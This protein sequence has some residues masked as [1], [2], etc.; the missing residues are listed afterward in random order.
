MG[1][2]RLIR[3]ELFLQNLFKKE[4]LVGCFSHGVLVG[5]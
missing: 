1:C 2:N 5:L 4:V 3:G